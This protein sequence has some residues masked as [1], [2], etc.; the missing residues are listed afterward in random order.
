VISKGIFAQG[1]EE[2][3]VPL[4]VLRGVVIEDDGHQSMNALDDDG[5]SL[6]RRSEGMCMGDDERP[7]G[8]ASAF[9]LYI[10]HC[11]LAL[12]PGNAL[13][14]GLGHGVLVVTAVD[15]FYSES[16]TVV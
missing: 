10:G 15:R 1:V 8:L 16:K 13:C 4:A 9:N 5:L 6:K 7:L 12:L 11:L 14:I 2:E 3:A